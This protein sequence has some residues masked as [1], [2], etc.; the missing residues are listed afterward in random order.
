MTGIPQ[1][2]YTLPEEGEDPLEAIRARHRAATPGPHRWRGNAGNFDVHLQTAWGGGYYVLGFERWGLREAQPTF[3]GVRVG[4]ELNERGWNIETPFTWTP[5]AVDLDYDRRV[6]PT[7]GPRGG[8]EYGHP[9]TTGRPTS[10]VRI[11]GTGRPVITPGHLYLKYEQPYRN[12]IVGIAHPDA[13]ALERAWEDR[14][15]LLGEVDRLRAALK[16]KEVN[17]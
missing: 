5:D 17:A 12:D 16:E 4:R 7:T 10:A 15:Y 2:S 6:G 8:M 11:A 14:D 13:I 9:Y 1:N 3:D